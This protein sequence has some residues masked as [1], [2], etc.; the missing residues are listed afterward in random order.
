M[1][2]SEDERMRLQGRIDRIDVCRKD[3]K[4]YVRVVDYK[5]GSTRFDLTS[6]YYGLQLQ[7]A[8]YL[9]AAWN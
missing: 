2:L 7:L 8:V 6:I 9:N 3:G 4:V 1:L 5:S